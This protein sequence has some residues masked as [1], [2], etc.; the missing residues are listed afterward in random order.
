MP[1]II[2]IITYK[3]ITLNFASSAGL[4]IAILSSKFLNFYSNTPFFS[5]FSFS[6][7]TEI[8]YHLSESNFI[9]NLLGESFK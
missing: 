1:L 7:V 4:S 8:F 3:K 9:L 5:N 2:K 6:T